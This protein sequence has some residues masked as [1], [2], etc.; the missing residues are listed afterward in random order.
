MFKA[1]IIEHFSVFG[2]RR[3]GGLR[4]STVARL[5][6]AENGLCSKTEQIERFLLFG[7]AGSEA[8]ATADVVGKLQLPYSRMVAKCIRCADRGSIADK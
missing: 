2:V 1:Q 6:D 8:C 4:Y 7:F 5:S 3:L